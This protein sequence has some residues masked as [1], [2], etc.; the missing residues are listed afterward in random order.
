MAN[1][2]V[3]PV[4]FLPLGVQPED[5]GNQRIPRAVVNLADNIL[6]AHEEYI[7]A[8]YIFQILDAADILEFMNQVQDYIANA[9]H[10]PVRSVCRHPF[11]IGL[12]HLDNVF[13]KDLVMA[14]NMHDIYC[15]QVSFINHDH[16]LN[17]MN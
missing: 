3:N 4:P 9:F 1:F 17:R 11:D 6:H 16:A 15:I 10:I 7:L 12:Y 2:A 8:I 14:C 5:G 13:D